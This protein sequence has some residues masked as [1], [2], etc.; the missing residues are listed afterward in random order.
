MKEDELRGTCRT[1]GHSNISSE[2]L[3][4]RYY[5]GDPDSIEMDYKEIGCKRLDC[6]EVHQDRNQWLVV[7]NTLLIF[8][9]H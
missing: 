8:W 7:V 9:F 6:V 5:L 3:E 2:N 4:G 1:H